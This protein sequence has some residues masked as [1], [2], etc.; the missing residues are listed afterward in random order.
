MEFVDRKGFTILDVEPIAEGGQALQHNAKLD[1]DLHEQHTAAIAT[2]NTT[3]TVVAELSETNRDS[4]NDKA[5]RYAICE[6]GSGMN[7]FTLK[8][9]VNASDMYQHGY[10]DRYDQVRGISPL[11]SATNDFSD[12]YTAKTYALAKMKLSQLFAVKLTHD[13]DLTGDG[14]TAESPDYKFAFDSGPQF[15]D[16]DKGD[17]LVRQRRESVRP[18]S[19]VHANGNRDRPEGDRHPD[20]VL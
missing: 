6:R 11:A 10:F 3:L 14:T 15:I 2:I 12:L 4:L 7:S 19:G 8:T 20:V 18:V 16:L 1:G 13:S 9:I 5:L 17:N